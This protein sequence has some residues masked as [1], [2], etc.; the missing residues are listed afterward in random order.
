MKNGSIPLLPQVLTTAPIFGIGHLITIARPKKPQTDA[1]AARVPDVCGRNMAAREIAVFKQADGT[2]ESPIIA[3]LPRGHRMDR[4]FGVVYDHIPGHSDDLTQIDGIR[5]R[6]AVLLNQSGVYFYG[7]IA[8][9]RHREIT[10]IASELQVSVSRIIDENWCEQARGLCRAPVAAAVSSLPASMLKT[11]TLLACALMMGFFAVYLLGQQRNQPLTGIL[12]ADITSIKVPAASRLTAV[13][14]RAGDEVFSGQPLLTL[15]KLEHLALIESQERL[16]RNLQRE[17]KRVEAQ[18]AIELEWR[19]RDLDQELAKVRANAARQK[20]ASTSGGTRSAASASVRSSSAIPVSPISSSRSAADSRPRPGGLLFFGASGQT[21]RPAV[22]SD[23]PLQPPLLS[24]PVRVAEALP[25]DV[26]SDSAAMNLSDTMP[27]SLSLEL[28]RLESVRLSLPET[29]S[30]AVGVTTLEAHLSDAAQ[31]LDSMKSVSREVNVPSPVYGTV[32]QVRYRKGDDMP[33]GEVMLRIL[34][35]DRRYITVYL[36][37]RRVHEMQP[38]R[39]VELVFPGNQEYR[40][41]IVDVPLLA[42]ASGQSG[43]TLAPVRIEPA[44]RL[45]P[46]VPVGSQIDVI[47]LK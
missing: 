24:S 27:D 10:S 22:G 31:L 41:Q 23:G 7:Q 28:A 26:V 38:G 17:L 14:V 12:A 35:T 32:G 13:H 34:H 20:T 39:E 21:S 36:P 40:G 15:E 6:E 47:S 11:V 4:L 33:P 9:W 16:V 25:N 3:N 19:A 44:G 5:T 8:L 42:E 30:E 29:I 1:V 46:T 18:A 37:T 2:M 43:E 45:W